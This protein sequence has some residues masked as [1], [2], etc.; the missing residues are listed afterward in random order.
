MKRLGILLLAIV[1]VV[2]IVLIVRGQGKKADTPQ[3]SP[4]AVAE[5]IDT[6]HVKDSIAARE[7]AQAK[8]DSMLM[9][10]LND[11]LAYINKEIKANPEDPRACGFL[12]KV[13]SVNVT[14]LLILLY[15]D[16]LAFSPVRG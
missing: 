4:Q 14:L 13:D 12:K 6:N 7:Q 3:E 15:V 5:V 9:S 2:A 1:S 16:F 8:L 11:S 10:Q